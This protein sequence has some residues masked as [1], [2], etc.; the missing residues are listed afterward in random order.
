M[1]AAIE[2]NGDLNQ[3]RNQLLIDITSEGLR[4]QIVD[5]QNRPMF[6]IGRAELQPYARESCSRSAAC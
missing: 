1:E 4:V 6:A 3:Y 2:K 5:E